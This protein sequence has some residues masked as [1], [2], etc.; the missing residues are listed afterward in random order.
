MAIVDWGVCKQLKV[1]LWVIPPRELIKN[2]ELI[3][4]GS[5]KMYRIEEGDLRGITLNPFSASGYTFHS[6]QYLPFYE[7]S[8]I[9]IGYYTLDYLLHNI[10]LFKD[11]TVDRYLYLQR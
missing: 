11:V 7:L 10:H 8:S 1:M 9:F 6:F 3:I 2:M 5:W 4:S